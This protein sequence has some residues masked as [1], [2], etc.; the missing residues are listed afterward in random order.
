[1]LPHI[2][3]L[4]A[5]E[6]S[7]REVFRV[8][9]PAA[10]TASGQ[11]VDALLERR[12]SPVVRRRLPLVL[13]RAES[14]LAVQGLVESLGD[15]DADVRLRC[16]KALARLSMRAPRLLF[17]EGDLWRAVRA[18]LNRL[19][20]AAG[21]E[22]VDPGRLGHLFDLLGI[23]YGPE[24]VDLCYGSLLSREPGARGTALEYLESSLPPEIRDQIWPLIGAVEVA[25]RTK[26]SPQAIAKDLLNAR[27]R[28]AGV[29]TQPPTGR[30][31]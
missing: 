4:L 1:L 8:L 22:T 15:T 13:A 10:Y 31:S 18:E 20:A 19:R 16:G 17:P 6:D 25:Q 23:L 2:I 12:M 29:R 14:Q 5:R 11:L 7:V 24:T 9:R 3:P 30:T 26:R 21:G 27:R 28:S